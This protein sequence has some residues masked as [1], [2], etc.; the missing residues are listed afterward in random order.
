M[1]CKW[2]L[3]CYNEVSIF[4]VRNV[5]TEPR[6]RSLRMREGSSGESESGTRRQ[7]LQSV[8]SLRGLSH[9]PV[10]YYVETGTAKMIKVDLVFFFT[11]FDQGKYIKPDFLL[12]HVRMNRK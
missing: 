7:S 11:L 9:I 3:K 4:P 10:R 6:S 5:V 12:F 8:S 1:S 2:R